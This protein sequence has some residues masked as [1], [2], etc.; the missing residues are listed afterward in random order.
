[1]NLPSTLK[2]LLL[3]L[4]CLCW[5]AEATF[6]QT[7]GRT[8]YYKDADGDGFGDL[9]KPK[10]SKT[11]LRG[12]VLNALDCNDRDQAIR[13]GATEAMDGKDN[14]CD[15]M[16]DEVSFYQDNDGDGFGS[17]VFKEAVSGPDGYA[18]SAWDCDDA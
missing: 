14:D 8:T 16:T 5:H 10:I 1:M 6:A 2:P 11:P 15:G 3:C 13:P 9:T 12:Y 7:A 17:A 18:A 4:A